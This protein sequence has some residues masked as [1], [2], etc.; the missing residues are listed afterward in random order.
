MPLNFA[1]ILLLFYLTQ[2]ISSSISPPVLI[3]YNYNKILFFIVNLF[4]FVFQKLLQLNVWLN[5]PKPFRPFFQLI[6]QIILAYKSLV[7]CVVLLGNHCRVHLLDL[8]Q[9]FPYQMEFLSLIYHQQMRQVLNF[10]K[11]QNFVQMRYSMCQD[12]C[13]LM[14]FR[15][16]NFGY[17][18]VNLYQTKLCYVFS[19]FYYFNLL[20]FQYFNLFH[21]RFQ[22]FHHL[23]VSLV[24]Q[25]YPQVLNPFYLFYSSYILTFFYPLY[26]NSAN[27]ILMSNY[28]YFLM[29]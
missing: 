22:N 5:L 27:L 8:L 11:V 20:S 18:K 19:H 10:L 1:P 17:Q 15:K 25:I 24:Y 29:E 9:L 26:L 21:P 6:F 16:I 4:L 23:S 3:F 28:D 14:D 2:L 13:Q 12:F 7:I